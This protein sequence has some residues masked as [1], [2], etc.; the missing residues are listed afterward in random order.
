MR[1]SAVRGRTGRGL[2]LAAVALTAMALGSCSWMGL[3]TAQSTLRITIDGSGMRS[4]GLGPS[5]SPEPTRFVLTGTMGGH[6]RFDR[7]S[8]SP[9]VPI[10]SVAAGTWT[11]TV[12]GYNRDDVLVATATAQVDVATG[13]RMV[14][15][16][17]LAPLSGPGALSLGMDWTDGALTLP[18]VAATLTPAAGEALALPFTVNGSTAHFSSDAIGS[19]YHTL[20]AQLFEE[21]VVVAGAA[22]LVHVLYG[23]ETTGSFVFDRLNQPGNL[24]I[25]IDLV[26]GFSD[27]LSVTVTGGAQSY[28]YGAAV[29]LSATV[30]DAPGNVVYTW[31]IN[32]TAVDVGDGAFTMSGYG[33]GFYRVDV[34]AVTADGLDGGSGSFSL[35]IEEAGV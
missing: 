14:L 31:Y 34:I 26:E 17:D 11:V 16:V 32:G 15:P 8:D 7:V 10:G 35:R 4:R 5:V 20:V 29:D 21:D 27:S 3:F 33:P 13:G 30:T 9:D 6:N 1:R 23:Q 25:G 24:E 18:A 12:D 2:V 28:P 22:E 19:G